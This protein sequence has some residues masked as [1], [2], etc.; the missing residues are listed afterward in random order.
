VNISSAPTKNM[1][2][3]AGVCSPT[4][5]SSVL[6]AVDLE[7]MLASSDVT[8]NTGSG[9]VTIE[10]TAPVAWASSQRLTLNAALNVS[11]KAVVAFEGTAGGVI[12]STGGGG[13]LL[14]FPGGKIDLWDTT[15]SLVVNGSSYVLVNDVATLASDVASNPSGFYALAKDYDAGP[16]GAYQNGI[17]GFGGLL[18]GL[19]HAVSNL[20]INGSSGNAVG[21]FQQTNS[22]VVI[23]DLS[24]ANVNIQAQPTNTG[25]GAFV[26]QG[27]TNFVNVSSSGTINGGTDTGGLIGHLLTGG[28]VTGSHSSA[29]VGNKSDFTVGGLVGYAEGNIFTSYDIGRISGGPKAALGGLAG[30]LHGQIVQS[31]SNA[32]LTSHGSVTTGG[33]VGGMSNEASVSDSYAMGQVTAGHFSTMGG[34]IG[35]DSGSISRSYSTTAVVYRSR[36]PQKVRVGGFAGKY[37]GGT[38]DSDYWDIDT[39]GQSQPCANPCHAV[40]GLSDTALKAGLPSGFD[41]AIWAQSPSINNGYPYLIANPP[42]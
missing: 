36:A 19:G 9:A 13:D 2:C 33:L 25:V 32:N 22:G 7:N 35:F 6:N 31:F 30:S 40:T 16:D 28:N 4:A 12:I 24:L 8:V 27:G 41:P 3:S 29:T 10:V 21:L 39:S 1:S 20:A 18:E 34:L 11:I 38:L 17:P 5:K 14:F 23:R 42:Q 15:D 37:S 26:G